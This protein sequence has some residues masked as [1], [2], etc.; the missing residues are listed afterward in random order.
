[1]GK[2]KKL[3]ELRMDEFSLKLDFE[4]IKMKIKAFYDFYLIF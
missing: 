2:E 1:M 3:F 4:V